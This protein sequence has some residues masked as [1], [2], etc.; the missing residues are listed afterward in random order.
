[1]QPSKPGYLSGFANH[2]LPIKFTL[3][4]VPSSIHNHSSYLLH[5]TLITPGYDL[6]HYRIN[7]E[8]SNYK[9]N[10]PQMICHE[11]PYWSISL[12][13]PCWRHMRYSIYSQLGFTYRKASG[14]VI[15]LV[16]VFG[17]VDS[18]LHGCVHGLLCLVEN[19]TMKMCSPIM[20]HWRLKSSFVCILLWIYGTHVHYYRW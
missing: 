19:S 15:F 17:A 3:Q 8:S 9:L 13:R 4:R 7:A 1:M 5:W 16:A 20:T 2:R 6:F 10:Y 11:T 12:S 14:I 18:S